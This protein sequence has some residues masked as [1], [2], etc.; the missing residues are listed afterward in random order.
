MERHNNYV[1]NILITKYNLQMDMFDKMFGSYWTNRH[2]KKIWKR[3]VQNKK[4]MEIQSI[5]KYGQD[6]KRNIDDLNQKINDKIKRKYDDT[7]DL[8]D[9]LW[10]HF[11]NPNFLLRFCKQYKRKL[12]IK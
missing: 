6:L 3:Y 12:K 5:V 11:A 9:Y 1:E 8:E 4:K 2:W 7:I 10:S